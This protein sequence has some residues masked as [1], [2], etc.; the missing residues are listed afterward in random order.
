[1]CSHCKILLS[2]DNIIEKLHAIK[3]FELEICVICSCN[4]HDASIFSFSANKFPNF[5]RGQIFRTVNFGLRLLY[6]RQSS[7]KAI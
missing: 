2:I 3:K 6:V 1:M 5:V 7:K 4:I